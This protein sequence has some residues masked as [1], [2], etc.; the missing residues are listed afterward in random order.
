MRAML[1]FRTQR[2]A[3]PRDFDRLFP[4]FFAPP[5]ASCGV[6]V[7][8]LH[9]DVEETDEAYL[10]HAEVPGVAREDLEIKV[11]GDVLTIAGEKKTT[12]EEPK[13]RERVFGSFERSL[14]LP[15]PIDVE[16]VKAES[17]DGVLIVTLPKAS[18]ERVKRIEIEG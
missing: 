8:S 7:P 6:R 4:G 17:R 16:G 1:P 12:V 5:A 2:A 15:T 14:E 3:F 11:A 9:L 13:L 10:V 18:A